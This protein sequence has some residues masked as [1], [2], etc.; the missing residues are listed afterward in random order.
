MKLLT[1]FILFFFLFAGSLYSQNIFES[2]YFVS[3]NGIRKECLIKRVAWDNSPIE[4]TWKK[5]ISS[6]AKTE[7]IKNVKE[8]G[9][10]QDYIFKRFIMKFDL[11][12]DNIGHSTRQ[13]DPRLRIRKVFLR[14]IV[15][16]KD[17]SLYQYSE[18]EIHR[19]FYTARK[20]YYPK[21]LVYKTYYTDDE[22]EAIGEKLIVKSNNK[23]R[24]Q[25]KN[26]LSC[27][28]QDPSKV[29][30]TQRDLK[31]YFKNFNRCKG[32]K[33]DYEIKTRLNLTHFGLIGSLDMIDF[34]HPIGE[35]F[36]PNRPVIY[37]QTK[38]ARYGIYFETFIPFYKID[39]SFFLE[40][41]YRAFSADQSNV[42]GTVTPL[43]IDYK[44]VNVNV[45]PRFHIYLSSK[46]ELFFDG[47]LSIDH[48][49]GTVSVFESLETT[50]L[51]YFY[52]GG[53]GIG[54]FKFGYRMYT[55]KNIVKSETLDALRSQ[56]KLSITSFYVSVN[57][58][59]HNKRQNSR[60]K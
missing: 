12:G 4:F 29:T 49:L 33:I 5:T 3:N 13:K 40:S 51:G 30:Y 44:S 24:E 2:G 32:S 15:K 20:I 56:S 28:D 57:L 37:E 11:M 46:T 52:G 31:N 17:A 35:G 16:G 14:V 6:S 26:T 19:F 22:K 42:T 43:S 50:T 21:L 38:A 7:T 45:A 47:G 60:F 27:K 54:R 8:F 55:D 41:T 9:V 53:L 36:D 25:L 10:G 39:L 18:N 34:S 59:K 23:F 58:S 1:P 48:D